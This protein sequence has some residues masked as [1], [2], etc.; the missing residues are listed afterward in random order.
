MAPDVEKAQADILSMAQKLLRRDVE[1][2]RVEVT[3][4]LI[5]E[6]LDKIRSL[7]SDDF[8]LVN[9]E[10]ILAELIRRW[11]RTV[12]RNA[13]LD[14]RGD[15]VDWLTSDRKRDWR[16]W[17]RYAEYMERSLPQ[18]AVDA[19]DEST[20]E[21]LRHLEDPVRSGSW[22]RRGLV[23]GHVQSGKTGNYTGLICKAADAGYKIIIVLAG[24]HNNLRSQ[25]QIRL[26]EGFLGFETSPN[27]DVLTAV[28]V[29]LE[30][31]DQSIRPNNGTNRTEK[32]DFNTAVARGF[33]V[34]P[35]DRPW[36]FVVKKER[37]GLENLI[38][39]IQTRVADVTDPVTGR[40]LVSG[41]PLIVIDDECDHGSVDT[42]E[43]VFYE[44]GLPDEEH[45]PTTINRLIRKLLH[46]FTRKAYVGYTATPFANIFIH[47]K[48]ETP[49]HG[50]DLFPSAFI[51]SLGAP[52]NY[53]G[54]GRV[55]RLTGEGNRPAIIQ[56]LTDENSGPW[57]P[58]GHKNGYLPRYNG[59]D[60]LPPSLKEAVRSFVY[61]CA[62]RKLRG[63]GTKHSSMLVH[64]TRFTS[65]QS[66][67]AKQIG[68]YHRA[69]K[70]RYQRGIDL[71]ET[72]ASMKKEYENS[73][74]PGMASVRK[75]LAEDE[76]LAD[77]SWEEVRA[78]IPDVLEDILVKE[79]NGSAK[80]ALEY[81]DRKATGLKVIAVGGDKLARGLTL[82]GLCTSYFVRTT[83]MY[84]TLMQ[85]GRWFGY[86]DGYLDVCRLYTSEDL[87]KWF[88]HITEAAEELR[89]HFDAMAAS[90]GTPRDFGM[91]VRSHSVLTVTS[92]AKMRHAKP[93]KITF[94]GDLLQTIVF[95]KDANIVKENFAAGA[96]LL[97]ALGPG[98]DL[99][100]QRYPVPGQKW[101][102]RLWR[103]A[104]ADEIIHFLQGYRTHSDSFRVRS[105]LIARF[106]EKMAAAGE[107]VDWTVALVGR[108]GHAPS[109]LQT[110]GSASVAMLERT[111]NTSK[112]SDRY[113]I[114]TLIS[115]RDQAI[116]LTEPQWCAALELTRKSWSAD[117][118]RN[119]GK[120]LPESPGGPAI[121]HVL[122]SGDAEAGLEHH[123]ERGLLLLYLLDPK[124]TGSADLGLDSKQPILAWALS[125]PGSSSDRGLSDKDYIANTIE[126]EGFSDGL[127]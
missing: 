71:I 25:T 122:G 10:E 34:T 2:N 22:D 7:L 26:D 11:S 106:V 45:N 47:G 23:V 31:Q 103:S 105:D 123:R 73:F 58:F 74:R 9:E 85:M 97:N 46:S 79:I 81:E 3:P 124:K 121:R 51:T 63:Q 15:H 108:S 4:A 92:R 91:R 82:E 27:Q 101:S 100:E 114:G 64:V 67:V 65:V 14:G 96:G 48:A 36:L 6:T 109:D 37:T 28:G 42:G 75:A 24:L 33:G 72:E 76:D 57:L 99:N 87:I 86:R 40:K 12:G 125:L 90:G 13:T 5:R 21:I 119:S 69:L 29:G 66:E 50:P 19:L 110:I 39:W 94:S 112:D 55:F 84:D 93:M 53:V 88:E 113:A 59:K 8:E 78:V 98:I 117:V 18:K 54:P 118:E 68:A 111:H 70:D 120:T 16:Y 116:D 95:D 62:I 52:S 35:E 1:R 43:Q 44:N 83:K 41:L 102:G 38:K 104:P 77:F 32:G 60:D 56:P 80:D 115:P 20:D 61:A 49:E 126:W 17:A 107:L 30:D 89:Q 127:G